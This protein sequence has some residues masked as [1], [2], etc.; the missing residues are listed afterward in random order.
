M[1]DFQECTNYDAVKRAV[2]HS[3]KLTPECYRK[4]F[5]ECTRLPGKSYAETARDMERKFLK[6]L[7]SEGARTI[8]EVKGLMVMEKFMSV[9]SP[10]IRVRVKEADIK[11]L[12]AAADRADMLE[13][14]LRPYRE[15]RHRQPIRSGYGRR[16]RRTDGWRT[17]ASSPESHLSSGDRRGSKTAV[18][19]VEKSQ[20]ESSRVV[21]ETEES[22]NGARKIHQRRVRCYNCGIFGHVV[23][24]CR[25][26]EQRG[27]VAFVRVEDQMSEWVRDEPVLSGEKRVHPFVCQGTVR[28]GDADPIPVKILRD[29]GADC[30]LV[31][32]TLF[33]KGYE[34][35]SV[36]MASV[37]TVGGPVRMPL[38][39]VT[40]NSD[41]GCQTFVVGVCASMPKMEAQ[42]ILGNDACGGYVLPN[43]AKGEECIEHYEETGRVLDA[44]GDEIGIATA[45]FPV[46]AVMPRQCEGH[47]GCGS[48][49]ADEETSD[50]PEIDHLFMEPGERAEGEGSPN[51]E[52]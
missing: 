10:E 7:D 45:A 33:P 6:W 31:S 28:M 23:R 4:R 26:P 20:A 25:H 42:V 16:Y 1:L 39:Q 11:D 50:S 34:S 44:C 27:N 14:A 30:T 41:Y 22:M 3:F 17:G 24:E 15:G 38:H 40:L 49:R 32:E 29:T 51:G 52:L 35:T 13:E 47:G 36:G 8:E 48:D 18:E 2:L 37:T 12:R 43:L 5:R 46:Y 21:A 19:P 9:L